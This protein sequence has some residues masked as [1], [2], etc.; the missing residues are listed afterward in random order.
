MKIEQNISL[1]KYHTFGINVFTKYFAEYENSEELVRFL[2]SDIYKQNK[3]L[4]I[5]SG[6]NLLFLQDY[7]GIILHSAIRFLRIKD[8]NNKYV[9]IEAGSGM[10]W[11]EF[12]KFCVENKYY[13]TENL[14]L[15]P[16][17][18]G[19][20]AVQNIGAYGSEVKDIIESVECIEIESCKTV[21]F[22]NDE[23]KYGYRD[24][25]FKNNL[26]GKYIITSV[27]F[28]LSKV[29]FF[30][31]GYQQLESEV[32]KKGT[33]SLENI[34]ETIIEIRKSKLPDPTITGN[35]GSFFMN[36]VI[37]KSHFI[38]LQKKFPQIPHYFVSE[39]EEKIPAGWLIEKCGWKGKNIG[40]AGV[41]DK[42]ALVIINKGNATGREIATL[43]GKIIESVKENFQITLIPEVNFID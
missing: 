41:H 2:Q 3:S 23:C 17:E 31:L 30:N 34:R 33:L 21:I 1:K 13:G 18:V 14:S 29:P 43:S 25:V 27:C 7:D 40:N 19:A 10:C 12:V 38:E 28:K 32:A 22:K 16:G 15:I 42:Q 11:D 20:S 36:P 9:V 6:S 39:Y 4:Q 24:S 8:E 5:G 35:A 26:R 37:K